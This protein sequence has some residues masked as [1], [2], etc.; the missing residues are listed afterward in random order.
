MI[1]AFATHLSGE[2]S[3]TT[4]ASL[5]WPSTVW[6]VGLTVKPAEVMAEVVGGARKDKQRGQFDEYDDSTIKATN[7]C[8]V[9]R[10]KV[11]LFYFCSFATQARKTSPLRKRRPGEC[12]G[13]LS[14][15][16]LM[17]SSG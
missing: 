17:S 15:Q 12:R 14:A 7:F 10:A 9:T 16:F 8:V 6:S 5:S 3:T 13:H 4:K 1:S 11:K 2:K